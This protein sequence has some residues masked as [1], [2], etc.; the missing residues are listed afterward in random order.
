MSNMSENLFESKS[1]NL[2]NEL[3]QR[4]AELEVIAE[5][6]HRLIE[7]TNL[8]PTKDDGKI[9]FEAMMDKAISMRGA[10]HDKSLPSRLVS[11]PSDMRDVPED[12][13]YE[14]HKNLMYL[15]AIT[16]FNYHRIL[17]ESQNYEK[18]QKEYDK[19]TEI[20]KEMTQKHEKIS[21]THVSGMKI[22][23]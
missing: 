15:L 2:S 20:M 3:P 9:D 18:Y 21:T 14:E 7:E 16:T 12:A 10:M 1:E 22:L 19:A 8:V 4:K 5:G 23:K 13:T 17:L 11:A 6:W